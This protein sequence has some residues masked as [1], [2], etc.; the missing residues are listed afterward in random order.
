MDLAPGACFRSGQKRDSRDR[1]VKRT[2]R[3]VVGRRVLCN[4]VQDRARAPPLIWL[5]V[6]TKRTA[7]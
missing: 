1:F 2:L 3:H 5:L 6:Q 7:A 4:F